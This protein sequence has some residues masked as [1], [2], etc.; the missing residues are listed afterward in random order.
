MNLF[1]Q[2]FLKKN[3]NLIRSFMSLCTRDECYLIIFPNNISSSSTS[4][5]NRT[6][7]F[8]EILKH[9][10]ILC[11]ICRIISWTFQNIEKY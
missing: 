3:S 7:A 10:V 11:L 9:F 1:S 6:E 8:P 2:R 5:R 4:F